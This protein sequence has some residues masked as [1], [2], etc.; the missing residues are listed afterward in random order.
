MAEGAGASVVAGI[1]ISVAED[2][3]GVAGQVFDAETGQPL[4]ARV[5]V[6]DRQGALVAT[7]YEHLPG[8][9]TEEDGR[10][11]VDLT[12]GTYTLEV[13]HGI[14]YVSQRRNFE[15]TPGAGVEARVALTPW[16]PLRALGWVNGDGHA[17]LY[18]DQHRDDP[19]LKTVRR[20]CRA[21]G[22]DFLAVC[23]GWAGY[24]DED[25]REG[26]AAFSD[27]HFLIHY[28]A[29]M[30][31]YRTGHTFWFGLGSTRGYYVESMD[32]TYEDE[33]YQVSRNPTWSFESL[34]FPSIP[35]VELVPRIKEAEGAVAVVPHP[36]SW[37][38]Q[39]RDD[40][41]K[42]TTNVGSHLAF[43]L[44]A[45][46]LWDALVVMG[47]DHD[48][49]FYQNLWFHV[50]NEGY[51]MTPVA[52]LDG[53][54]DPPSRFYYGSM[55][56]YLKVGPETSMDRVV[57]AVKAGRTFVTSGPIV[58]AEIDDRYE[59]GD[60]V[61]AD[62]TDHRL[63]IRA[64]ASGDRDDHLS[65][66]VLFRNGRVHRLW[67]LRDQRRRRLEEEVT[68]RETERAWYVVKVYG[69]NAGRSPE[70][71]DVMRVC[72][73]I[74]AGRPVPALS[75]ESDVAL[76]SPFYFR[77]EGAGDPAALEAHVR[78]TLVEPGAGTPVAKGR[79]HVQLLGRTVATHEVIGG[80]AELT[81]PVNAVLVLDVP[82]HPPL[83][84]SLYL[85]YRPYRDLM[86]RLATGRWLDA[87]GGKSR[88]HPG[89]VP[90][91]AFHFEEA[92][93][94]LREV[95]WTIAL[96]ANE[97]DGLWVRLGA[98]FAGPDEDGI[99]AGVGSE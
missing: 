57:A 93:A 6:R 50:L 39:E 85:D 59:V 90:W 10:F 71:L 37:W 68:L 3:P 55:R 82:D 72:D 56:T 7:R 5:V 45:G 78:L 23:Q 62:G 35:D 42:Y 64:F 74:V 38:W 8:I 1:E 51:R 75:P 13:H 24:G 61:P 34:P 44:L 58:L 9:F 76:T 96:K 48:H 70:A 19:M 69:G 32:Q 81:M 84:R 86:E 22:V 25:W 27:E 41:E 33:Y 30:P 36:T 15:V 31:K 98:L 67:D 92:R 18:T 28:G 11:S 88:L 97:R 20:I 77:P 95:E 17:H 80:R 91:E 49:Y 40:V 14:D 43:G 87:Y 12:P 65:Y 79:V 21:Q 54:Y 83:W 94:T 63:R 52:E 73:D 66:V 89:Q 26:Y 53:G 60:V 16:V 99:E 47:Y 4:P 29:E 46:G 2:G